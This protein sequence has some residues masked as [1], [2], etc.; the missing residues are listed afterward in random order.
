MNNNDKFTLKT[1]QTAKAIYNNPNSGP[2]FGGGWDIFILNEANV[3][4]YSYANIGFSYSN[5][6]YIYGDVNSQAKFSGASKF[7]VKD[8]EVWKIV[9]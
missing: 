2:I 6:A 5:A 8:Y 9:F 1:E 7:M 3:N 4:S